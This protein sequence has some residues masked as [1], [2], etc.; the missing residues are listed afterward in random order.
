MYIY[1]YIYVYIYIR[2]SSTSVNLVSV[3]FL[4]LII[5]VK[6]IKTEFERISRIDVNKHNFTVSFNNTFVK[7]LG[8]TN[9]RCRKL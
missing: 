3:Y 4:Q 8:R 9:F 2:S 5:V 6:E 7:T 1:I